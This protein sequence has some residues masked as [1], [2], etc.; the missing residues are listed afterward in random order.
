MNEKILMKYNIIPTPKIFKQSTAFSPVGKFNAAYTNNRIK[1]I[2]GN[3]AR[4]YSSSITFVNS[5]NGDNLIFFLI[6]RN[7]LENPIEAAFSIGRHYSFEKQD[8]YMLSVKHEYIIALSRTS[9]GIR[10]ALTTLDSL[11]KQSLDKSI[12]VCEIEDWP[13][14]PMRGAMV[15]YHQMHDFMPYFGPNFKTLSGLYLDFLAEIKLNYLLIEYET[16]F[17]WQK[18]AKISCKDAFTKEQIMRLNLKAKERGIEIIPLVQTLGHV[19]HVLIHKEY[20]HIGEDTEFPQQ[21]CPLKEETFKFVCTLIDETCALHPDSHYIHIG[22]DECRRLGVCPTCKEYAERHGKY[23]LYTNYYNKVIEYVL[24]KGRIPILWHDM[25]LK[26]KSVLKHFSDK[27]VFHF[28]NYSRMTHGD[29]EQPLNTLLK[30]KKKGDIVGGSAARSEKFHGNIH[31][32]Y[33]VIFENIVEMNQHMFQK[34]TLGSILTDWPDSGIPFISSM[35]PIQLQAETSWNADRIKSNVFSENYEEGRFGLKPSRFIEQLN[36]ISGEIL[37]ANADKL[38]SFLNRYKFINYDIKKVINTQID[39]IGRGDITSLNKLY[40]KRLVLSSL[41]KYLKSCHKSCK[42]NKYE[43]KHY[44]LAAR[45]AFLFSTI[46][47]AII[48]TEIRRKTSDMHS[49]F[50]SDSQIK[51]DVDWSLSEWDKLKKDFFSYYSVYSMSSHLKNHIS[52]RFKDSIKEK[53]KEIS[54]Y[55]N[56]K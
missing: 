22:G 37:F 28:W 3:I 10:Y 41:I 39:D 25:A 51:K 55:L 31:P 9:A 36:S 24:S 42:K 47:I 16:L 43:L 27:V 1:F 5:G 19:Y 11:L 50:Y 23:M 38:K 26:D 54:Q 53:L 14:M 2:P 33:P 32:P 20:E 52:M 12:P 13:S 18:Y 34:K 56:S 4:L 44:I 6:S 8:K 17:P 35:L 30:K 21:F 15:C 29:M 40:D 45:T 46:A 49:T 48:I 7:K